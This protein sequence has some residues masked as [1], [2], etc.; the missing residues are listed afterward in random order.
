MALP[1]VEQRAALSF[2]HAIRGS[3]SCGCGFGLVEAF[4]P[5][6]GLNGVLLLGAVHVVAVLSQ[7][8]DLVTASV[9]YVT[10]IVPGGFQGLRIEH[11]EFGDTA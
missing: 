8:A 7:Q 9:Q 6:L 5:H 2:D 1:R 11:S 4:V 3:A 10:Q